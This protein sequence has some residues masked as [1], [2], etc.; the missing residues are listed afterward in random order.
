M[1]FW[2]D[3]IEEVDESEM[4]VLTPCLTT[5]MTSSIVVGGG[6]VLWRIIVKLSSH[7]CFLQE[8]ASGLSQTKV[9][10]MEVEGWNKIGP[11]AVQIWNDDIPSFVF[12]LDQ[13]LPTYVPY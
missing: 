5:Y 9:H 13:T 6:A 3:L 11:R 10:E 12:S 1:D 2:M 8:V 7:C 4:H